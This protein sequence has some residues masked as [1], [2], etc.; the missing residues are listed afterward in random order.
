MR[1]ILDL[2]VYLLAWCI[3]YLL[4]L[5]LIEAVAINVDQYP[6]GIGLNG[7]EGIY[8]N[9]FNLNGIDCMYACWRTPLL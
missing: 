6:G 9:L 2:C 5:W 8:L 3:G 4:D 7:N 1:N